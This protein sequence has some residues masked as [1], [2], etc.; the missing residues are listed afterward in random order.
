MRVLVVGAGIGG[1]G[2]AAGLTRAGIE[3]EVVE[4]AEQVRAHGSGVTLFANGFGALDALGIGDDVRTAAGAAGTYSSGSRRPDGSWLMRLGGAA[5]NL[6]V[7]DRA[8]L[9]RVL[10]AAVPRDSVRTA[11]RVVGLGD[12]GVVLEGGTELAA[13]V[14]VGADGL[15]SRVRADAFGDP[16]IRYAGYG[17]WR[18]ITEHPVPIDAAGETLGRGARFGIAPLGDGRIYWFACVSVAPAYRAGGL[19][20]VR[21]RFGDWHDP[22]GALL[23]ATDP[24]A[25]S[26]AP[27]EELARRLRTFASGRCALLGDAA[28]AMTPNLGQ[29]ANQA[30][31]DAAVLN[32]LLGR[33]LGSAPD[34]RSITATL[35]RY[36]AL[37]RPRT[38]R[39]ARQARLLGTVMQWRHPFLA[40][41]RDSA[42]RLA[43]TALADRQA[44]NLQQWS[45][46]AP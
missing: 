25:V 7:I 13:D 31:E 41:V 20:E 12:G 17:A 29:G 4:Q 21:R 44:R 3:V 19:D 11:S 14:V 1:L 35:A 10:L 33:D 9:Y 30:L 40:T 43:P 5:E 27:I 46:P 45:L 32:H 39:I 22:I 16:G 38:Q 34:I 24:A 37:R 36:D 18:G 26:Y 42:I 2:L 28:H 8:E 15:R 6:R 23:D